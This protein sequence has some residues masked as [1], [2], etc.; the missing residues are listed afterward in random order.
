MP[1]VYLATPITS[2]SEGDRKLIVRWCEWYIENHLADK[3]VFCPAIEYDRRWANGPDQTEDDL[4][5]IRDR[6]WAKLDASDELHVVHPDLSTNAAIE[7]GYAMGLD[8]KRVVVIAFEEWLD[9]RL[10]NYRLR[11]LMHNPEVEFRSYSLVE[12]GLRYPDP[13]TA[14]K[15]NPT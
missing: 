11:I 12:L 7:F 2:V 14:P 9:R 3:D 1:H 15:S 4:I 13:A 6:S 8:L 10:D 5:A